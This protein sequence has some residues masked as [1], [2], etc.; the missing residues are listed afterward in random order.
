M[1]EGTRVKDLIAKAG[2]VSQ[3]ASNRIEYISGGESRTLDLR[4]ILR[5]GEDNLP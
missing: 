5:D 2:G 1:K 4:N 3:G